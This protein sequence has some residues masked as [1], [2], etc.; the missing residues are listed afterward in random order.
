MTDAYVSP[1]DTVLA[2]LKAALGQMTVFDTE[3]P[4]HSVEHPLPT[5][6]VVLYPTSPQRSHDNLAHT[7]DTRRNVWQTTCVGSTRPEVEWLRT[8]VC[9]ALVDVVLAITGQQYNPLEHID[10]QPV[11]PDNEIPGR[12]VLYGV[13]RFACN[14]TT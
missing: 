1:T 4:R 9:D 13:D 14:S 8:K 12:V 7:S 10:A 6:Y 2:K 5:R 11:L 3:V